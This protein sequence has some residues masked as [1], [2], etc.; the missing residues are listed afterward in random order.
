MISFIK[1]TFY[2]KFVV[3][4]NP[5]W[6]VYILINNSKN[7]YLVLFILINIFKVW[8]ILKEMFKN[9]YTLYGW[10]LHT[11]RVKMLVAQSR[12]TLCDP[13][14]DYSLLGSSLH[15]ILQASLLECVAIPFSRGSSRPR[16]KSG[17]PGLQAG[18]LSSESPGK[19]ETL[20][21]L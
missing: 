1:D 19:P 18:F 16:I 2:A 21:K 13:S 20:S 11:W 5:C 14:P 10:G 4:C 6:I 12:L 17:S 15:G 7:I 8:K 9:L 3:Y